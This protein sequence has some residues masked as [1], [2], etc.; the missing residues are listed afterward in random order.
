MFPPRVPHPATPEGRLFKAFQRVKA[1][2]EEQPYGVIQ[3]LDRNEV[4]R[5]IP[6][7]M[8]LRRELADAVALLIEVRSAVPAEQAARIDELVEHTREAV[9]A[10]PIGRQAVCQ[11]SCYRVL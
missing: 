8:R 2:L 4:E 7:I 10:V 1:S 9:N 6:K 3:L 5:A 11:G